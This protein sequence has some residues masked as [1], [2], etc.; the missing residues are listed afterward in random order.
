MTTRQRRHLTPVASRDK[1]RA[2]AE[3]ILEAHSR[4]ILALRSRAQHEDANEF[5]RE[6]D[7]LRKRLEVV[8]NGGRR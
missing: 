1:L 4:F 6:K 2:A 3:E 7:F 5:T 8:V